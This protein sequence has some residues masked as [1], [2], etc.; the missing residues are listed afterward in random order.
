MVSSG[1]ITVI[2]VAGLIFF[3]LFSSFNK[4]SRE[5]KGIE[6]FKNL[7]NEYIYEQKILNPFLIYKDIEDSKTVPR[8]IL[9]KMKAFDY[10]DAEVK[11][12]KSEMRD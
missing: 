2:V 6:R 7:I 5:K 4:K 10:I 1:V 12:A 8:E 9:R 3:V 11:K